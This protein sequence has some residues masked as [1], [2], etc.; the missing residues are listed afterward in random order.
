MELVGKNNRHWQEFSSVSDCLDFITLDKYI[1]RESGVYSGANPP[2]SINPSS[3]GYHRAFLETA[4]M[5]R[6]GWPEGRDKIEEFV[7]D[8]EK[9]VMGYLPIVEVVRDVQGDWLDMGALIQGEPE[10]WGQF[11]DTDYYQERKGGKII[12]VVLNIDVTWKP[13]ERGAAGVAIIDALERSGHRVVADAVANTTGKGGR[14]LETRIRV[15]ESS[16]PVQLDKLAF[17]FAHGDILRHVLFA[18]WERLPKPLR[19]LYRFTDG[20][21]GY[22]GPVPKEDQGDIY[23][24]REAGHKGSIQDI[25]NYVLDT[26]RQNGIKIQEEVT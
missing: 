14:L 26:L 9:R 12:H 7:I 23:V 16:E 20:S 22:V 8:I 3:S 24:P 6:D 10:C 17:L 21:Y 15:K 19:E 5:M 1:Q 2:G 13:F 4:R 25:A 18:S 11:R